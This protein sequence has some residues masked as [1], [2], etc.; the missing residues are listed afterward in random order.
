MFKKNIRKRKQRAMPLD[1]VGAQGFWDIA[2]GAV[3]TVAAIGVIAALI[4][5]IGKVVS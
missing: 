1:Y 5:F 4:I 3:V 2:L